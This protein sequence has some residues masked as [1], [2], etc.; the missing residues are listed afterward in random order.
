M[1]PVGKFYLGGL[2][3]YFLMNRILVSPTGTYWERYGFRDMVTKSIYAHF[4]V[5]LSL[6]ISSKKAL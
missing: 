4:K 6:K 3:F 2:Y 5:S 1:S